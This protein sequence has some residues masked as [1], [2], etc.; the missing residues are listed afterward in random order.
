MFKKIVVV[1]VMVFMGLFSISIVG[2]FWISKDIPSAEEIVNKSV[3]QSTKIYDRTGEVLLYEIYG[4]EK[5]T[6]IPVEEIP[7]FI[8]YA[9]IS[10]E[11]QSFYKHPAFDIKGILRAIFIDLSRGGLIQG[12]STI[13]QQL[14][15][16]SFLTHERTIIRKVKEL[17]L[18][19]RLEKQYTKE[20]ILG[21]YLNQV[22]YGSNSYGVE[23]AAQVF[24]DKKAQDLD[25]NESALLAALP[26]APS[27]YS[28]WGE[29]IDSLYNRKDFVLKQMHELGYI[30]DVELEE[31]YEK[32]PN[33]KNRPETGI[34]APH[35]VTYIQ[36]Y[37]NNKYGEDLLRASGF[38]IITTLDWEM[39]QLAEDV[40]RRGAERNTE[41][42]GG[43]NAALIAQD[44]QTGQILA[45]VGSADYFNIENEG[46]FNV[47]V[48]GLRQPGSAFKP[49]AFLT[50]FEKGFTPDTLVW[51]VETEFNTT[52]DLEKSYKPHNF[53]E[54]FRGPITLKESL[55]QSINV[56]SVKT[57]Y[58]AGIEDTIKTA[59][60]MGI[61]TLKD[62]SRFGLSLVLGGGE[63]K[64]IELVGAYSVFA[65]DGIKHDISTILEIKDMN[66]KI[67]EQYKN[68][69]RRVVDAKYVRLINDILSDTEL[70][71]PL[72][73]RSI[74]LTRVPGH[75]I[76]LKTGTTNDYIDAWTMGYAPNLSVGVWVGNNHRE[77]LTSKGGSILAA[78]P[79][80]HDFISKAISKYPPQ[81]FER[82]EATSSENP[83]LRGSFPEGDPHTV[84]Y[85]LN[86]VND[87][88]F[89][90][91]EDGLIEWLKNNTIDLSLFRKVDELSQNQSKINIKLSSPENGSMINNSLNLNFEIE[92]LN[93]INLIEIYFNNE[94]IY[95]N[96]DNLG[97]FFSYNQNVGLLSLKIQNQLTISVEDENGF[98]NK[99]DIIL[100]H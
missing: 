25:L 20:E 16:N 65:A 5:R 32:I 67:V 30:D 42:Y 64:L 7:D 58:L 93:K 47:A 40:I 55:A 51:D 46:N 19:W 35:F 9:T 71:S 36:E 79:I 94:V 85:Y 41:L 14:A 96:S 34:K 83:I 44:P 57:L 62:R 27:Y 37:L 54:K 68:S 89:N 98:R 87:S 24:F 23:A 28:P 6:I 52:N 63:V 39:Q 17:I 72:F 26:K 38:K 12:G 78:V 100:F 75:Q 77:P 82:Q 69:S 66:N 73:E 4:E 84:L 76:A 18:A 53:D 48:K 50:A 60:D 10:V 29:N 15:K 8:K 31:N 56:P 81:I 86:K 91:W 21:F 80:W 2:V 88:Q 13:T 99:R 90:N 59:E 43:K 33:I 3:A 45:M 97:N 49:F 1:V 92:S 70:R 61:T 74:N 95:R 11:D 22:P